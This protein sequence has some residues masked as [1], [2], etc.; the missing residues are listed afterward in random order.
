M[1]VIEESSAKGF[2][3][4]LVLNVINQVTI[5][6]TISIFFPDLFWLN[7]WLVGWRALIEKL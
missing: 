4:I 3:I 2:N 1:A 5:P 6:E 7:H